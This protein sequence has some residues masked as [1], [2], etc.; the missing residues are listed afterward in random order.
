MAKTKKWFP[1]ELLITANEDEDGDVTLAVAPAVEDLT[2]AAGEVVFAARYQLVEIGRVQAPR[3]E[4]QANRSTHADKPKKR[5]RGG[6]EY[7][8]IKPRSWPV[9]P[10]K[11]DKK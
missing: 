1:H 3:A 9:Y 7:T 4:F 2:L 8:E 11:K 6:F 5:T 10:A